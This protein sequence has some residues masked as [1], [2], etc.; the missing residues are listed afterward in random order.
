M[1]FSHFTDRKDEFRID[2]ASSSGGFELRDAEQT[3][4]LRS[5]GTEIIAMAGRKIMQGDFNLTR[6]SFPIKCMSPQSLLMTVTGFAA[7]L[8]VYMNRA[9]SE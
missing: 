9:A 2:T 4:L 5:A 8:P 6:I 7:T 1:S 3:S